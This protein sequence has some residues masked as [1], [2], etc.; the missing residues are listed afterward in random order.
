MIRRSRCGNSPSEWGG[1]SSSKSRRSESN[2]TGRLSPFWS[3]LNPSR[4][5]F[6]AF[7]W[8]ALAQSTRFSI[9]QMNATVTI[10]YDGTTINFKIYYNY[11]ETPN[12]AKSVHTEKYLLQ[13]FGTLS[14]CTRG[15][16]QTQP[17]Q[18]IV[19]SPLYQVLWDVS[20][21]YEPPSKPFSVCWAPEYIL[22]QKSL[23]F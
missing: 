19:V 5:R 9:N 20:T 23:P 14:F 2:E 7:R 1:K 18:A 3:E 6:E 15:E 10:N 21:F 17:K 4:S 11:F 22:L 16:F 12:I 8:I 13:H